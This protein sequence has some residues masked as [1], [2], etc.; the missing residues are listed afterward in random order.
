MK[1]KLLAVAVV[2]ALASPVAV[3]QTLY[4]IVDVGYQNSKYADGDVNKHFIQ[5]GQHSGS[6]LGVRGSE[7][8]AAGTYVMY[9]VEFNIVADTGGPGATDTTRLTFVGLGSKGVGLAGGRRPLALEA[10]NLGVAV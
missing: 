6:R 4:G 3:A 1:K 2:G 9:Q 8:L 7:D 10:W 5:S